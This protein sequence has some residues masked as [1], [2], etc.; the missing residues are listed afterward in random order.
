MAYRAMKPELALKQFESMFK[1]APRVAQFEAVDNILP[2][3]YLQDVLPFVSTP[4]NSIIFYEV[5]ADLSEQDIQVLAKA[6]VKSIQPGIESLATST[7]KLM[8]KGRT[9]FKTLLCLRTARC[10]MF[11][12]HGIFLR[13]FRVRQRRFTRST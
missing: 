8:K 1:Y 3:S 13:D 12:L 7:L 5:K 4:P 9:F 10:T 11:T 6:R 2:K